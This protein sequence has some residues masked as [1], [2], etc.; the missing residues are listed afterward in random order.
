MDLVPYLVRLRQDLATAADPGSEEAVAAAERLAVVLEPSLQLLLL[1][2]L[3]EAAGELTGGLSRSAQPASGVEVRLRGREVE[4][5]TTF[6]PAAAPTSAP[7]GSAD[8]AP[9]ATRD[10]PEDAGTARLSLRVP[11]RLK[12]RIELAADA[13]GQSV[14]AWLVRS[15]GDVLDRRRGPGG[16]GRAAGPAWTQPP[17][18]PHSG[19]RLTGWAR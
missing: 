9:D 11:E 4:F 18:P 10:V 5:V 16:T 19:E 17:T 1:D 14:N 6:A 3:V 8:V 15:I 2:V 7:D 12:T 13:E